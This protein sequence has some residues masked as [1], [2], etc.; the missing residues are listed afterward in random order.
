MSDYG[1]KCNKMNVKGTVSDECLDASTIDSVGGL[2]CRHA[3]VQNKRKFVH[4]VCIK[5][6]VK[7][8]RTK[9]SYCSCTPIWPA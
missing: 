3:G 1:D 2:H 7:S 4:I 9:K 6:E 5:M 8:Q